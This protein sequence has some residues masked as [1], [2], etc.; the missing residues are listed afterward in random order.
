VICLLTRLLLPLQ[1]RELL[2]VCRCLWARRGRESCVWPARRRLLESTF[3]LDVLAAREYC[4]AD[5]RWAPAVAFLDAGDR[6]GWGLLAAMLTPEW[7]RR[8]TAASCLVHPF[9]AGEAA[10]AS[11]AG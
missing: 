9:L 4:E 2:S 5:E 10:G 8:P 1:R 7:R 11:A 6:A 3:Q